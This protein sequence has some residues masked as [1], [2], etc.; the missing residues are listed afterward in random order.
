MMGQL[1]EPQRLVKDMQEMGIA[2]HGSEPEAC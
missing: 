1:A 2:V